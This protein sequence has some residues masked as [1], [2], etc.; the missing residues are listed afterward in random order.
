VDSQLAMA[1]RPEAQA[2]LGNFYV[3]RGEGDKAIAAYRTAMILEPR[4]VPAR[5]NLAD[6]YSRSGNEAQAEAV[7]REGITENPSN[8]DLQHALGLTLIRQKRLPEAVTALQLGARLSPG[9]PR[10]VYVYAVAL[11]STGQARQA[12]MV[13]QGAHNA[14]PNDRDILSALVAF[15]RDA[16]NDEQA[17][18]YAQKLKLFEQ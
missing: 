13:L 6:F 16:C 11:N 9:N 12:I 8:G 15:N 3:A 14:H 7:L 18:R 4:F 10:Y 2:N 1:E 17:A 5:I